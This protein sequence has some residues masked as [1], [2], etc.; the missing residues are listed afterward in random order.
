MRRW[1]YMI[2]NITWGP[3]DQTWYA[4]VGDGKAVADKLEELRKTMPD[5]TVYS[6]QSVVS[7]RDTWNNAVHRGTVKGGTIVAASCLLGIGALWLCIKIRCQL[8]KKNDQED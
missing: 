4:S 7:A 1:I 8:T 2:N 5:D 6:L 3:N